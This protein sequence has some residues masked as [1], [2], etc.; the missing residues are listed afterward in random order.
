MKAL[1][2]TGL[3][4]NKACELLQSLAKV[5][6][7]FAHRD[8]PFDL[9][10]STVKEHVENFIQKAAACSSRIAHPFSILR[11]ARGFLDSPHRKPFFGSS[12]AMSR[13]RESQLLNE[14]DFSQA[15]VFWQAR[16]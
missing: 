15:A 4:D 11:F 5:R 10:Y 8:D 3:I 7:E 13:N 16:P 12:L 14:L 2:K 9:S 1:L 6:N